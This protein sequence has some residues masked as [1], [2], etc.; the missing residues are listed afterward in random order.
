MSAQT[1]IEPG[2]HRDVQKKKLLAIGLSLAIAVMLMA[3]KFYVYSITHSAAIL[4]D[5][6]ESIINVVAGAFALGSIIVAAR[7][8][9]ADHPYGH[10]KIEFFS[11]GFEGALIIIA[12]L[13]IFKTGISHLVNPQELPNLGAGLAILLA[14]TIVNLFLGLGLLRTGRQ[15]DSLTLEADGRHV[16]TDVYT[17]GGVIVGLLLVQISG[18]WWLDGAIACLVGVNIVITGFGLV[19]QSYQGLMDAAN[20]GVLEKLARILIEHRRPC[21]VDIHKLRAWKAGDLTHVDLHLVLPKELSLEEA[22]LEVI[23]MEQLIM[24]TF[25]GKASPLI[26]VD[27]CND[28]DCPTCACHLCSSSTE[29]T[30]NVSTWSLET[31]INSK[32]DAR[33]VRE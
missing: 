21:W 30:G 10:G 32:T 27:P 22:H 18:W 28:R 14:T 11:A 29:Q 16:L 8:P 31:F 12:A 23:K 24:N 4:S 13:G 33:L 19:R 1:D 26:H 7:P 2:P 25:K 15:T 17:S 3:I 9:D 20:P 5:A 6:L